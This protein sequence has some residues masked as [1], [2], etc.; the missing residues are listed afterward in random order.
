MH[1]YARC[2]R[3]DKEVH[4]LSET[5]KEVHGI[6]ITDEQ[7]G[8]LLA[9]LRAITEIN[10]TMNLTR[11]TSEEEGIV[12]HLED[13]LTG[14]PYID[15]APEGLY[16]DL[17]TGGGFPG[18]PICL[19][20]GRKTVLVDSVKKK[21]RAVVGVANELGLSGL[22]EGYD[23]R[24]EDLAIERKGQFA[25]LSARALSSLPSLMEL[26]CPLLMRNG[27]LVCY[28]AQPSDEELQM[29]SDIESLLE[30]KKIAHDEFELSDG[31][32]RCIIVY[33]K[34]DK[35]HVKLP[36]RVGLAQK[37]PL[38]RSGK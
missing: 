30:M 7:E 18:V 22:I 1:R 12:L 37:T 21:I 26:A 2:C 14:L 38:V 8:I 25:V 27:R 29:A 23:G 17:G 35:P 10:K 6:E 24:I 31:S 16:G 20:T 3:K 33:E 34:I 15:A 9:D 19:M 5:M 11:I 36:R 4:R 28:K 32:K 13:S